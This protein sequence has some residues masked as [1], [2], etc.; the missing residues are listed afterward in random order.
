MEH[1]I[2][3]DFPDNLALSLRMNNEEFSDEVRTMAIIKLYELGKIS[4]GI[5]S[6]S[7]SMNR[8]DFL[9]MLV[10]YKVSYIDEDSGNDIDM[11]IKFE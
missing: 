4:S 1:T 10:R 7:L 9:E 11:S 3:V 6:K 2:T 8:I 5:A